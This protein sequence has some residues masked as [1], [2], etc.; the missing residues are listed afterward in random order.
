MTGKPLP[1]FCKRRSLFCKIRISG[2]GQNQ[3]SKATGKG[4]DN[5]AS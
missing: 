4:P 2:W 3:P 1:E 5:A